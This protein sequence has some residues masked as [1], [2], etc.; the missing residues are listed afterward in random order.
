MPTLRIAVVGASGYSG[1]ELVRLVSRHPELQLTAITSRSSAGR[2]VG[3]VIPGL[4]AS[5]EKL[6][7]ADIAPADL[8]GHADAFFLALP[9]GVAAEYAVPL[10]KAGKVVI[11]LSADFRLK[12]PEIY[13]EFYGHDH[14]AP[15]LL[16]ESVYALP[17]LHRDAIKK[18]DLIACPGCYPTSILL[19]LAPALKNGL[20]DPASIVINSLSG[21]SGAGKKADVSLL[22]A[23]LNE[24]MKAYSVPKHR[25]LSEIEQELSLLAAQNVVVT[26][27]PHL[28]PLTRGMITTISAKVTRDL[29][30]KEVESLYAKY[31][32]GEPFV[33]LKTDGTL[34]EVKRVVRSNLIEIA[35]RLDVRT[36][37]LL[38]FSAIDNLG[39]GAAA[40][41][42]QALN[43]RFG[44]EE[45]MGLGA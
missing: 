10:R 8:A 28:V 11:D 39:K 25:H 27:I 16:K 24:S 4:P 1:E 9:H 18:T 34:P 32:T 15:E 23:E 5:L 45:T 44:F 12:S 31:Y 21:V 38:L 13:K 29:A 36:G 42:V 30:D 41:A 26:F 43:V 19:A 3:S 20:I 37:R 35:T 6:T 33:M 7:F 14:P 2:P 22:F 17:E 40:Q